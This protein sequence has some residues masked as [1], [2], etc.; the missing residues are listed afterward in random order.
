VALVGDCRY[1][2]QIGIEQLKLKEREGIRQLLEACKRAGDRPTDISFGIAPRINSISRI[3][4][5]VSNC[6][7]LLTSRDPSHLWAIGGTSRTC[8]HSAQSL[9]K[10]HL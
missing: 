9:A 3:W 4:G 2:A 1:L 10:E 6:V 8:Q 5:D 7:E